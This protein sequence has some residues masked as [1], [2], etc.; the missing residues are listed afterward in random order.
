MKPSEIYA[1]PT[2]HSENLY[3]ADQEMLQD[4]F[5]IDGLKGFDFDETSD[6]R[7]TTEDEETDLMVRRKLHLG[8]DSNNWLSLHTIE[9][10]GVPF[11][12]VN[13]LATDHSG[14]DN[15]VSVTDR[16]TYEAAR[17][18]VLSK[19]NKGL[20]VGMLVDADQEMKLAFKG[21]A[22][23]SIGGQVRLLPR[24]HVGFHTGVAIFDKAALDAGYAKKLY[25][26]KKD[27]AFAGGLSSPAAAAV[28]ASIVADAVIA[29]RKVIVGEFA[30][31]NCW[32]ACFFQ[33]DGETYAATVEASGL[34]EKAIHWE[35]RVRIERVGFA[36]MY[37]LVESF[38]TD[39]RIDLGSKA[40]TDYADAFGLTQ[41]EANMAI[42]AVAKGGGDFF[43]AA[44]ALIKERQP[45]PEGYDMDDMWIHARLLSENN[46]LAF[47]G[48][49]RMPSVRQAVEA[50][51]S[52][53]SMIKRDKENR[54]TRERQ[55]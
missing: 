5:S 33:A 55:P 47:Y 45:R 18:W 14:N 26:L 27:P 24:M 32:I 53:Q 29:D 4:V 10:R 17:D 28:A 9:F 11:A 25:P 40:A 49:G 43:E 51:E 48:L 37:D 3:W 8:L 46:K 19:M 23:T 7:E 6:G 36:P 54:D 15:D 22:L 1:L 39:G 30:T 20:D 35:H 31:Q 12:V 52:R 42:G 21:A 34:Y 16:D 44:V 2:D 38:H 41:H 13:R 50:W